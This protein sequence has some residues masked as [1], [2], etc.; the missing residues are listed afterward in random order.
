[1]NISGICRNC[2]AKKVNCKI[3]LG[4]DTG[5]KVA[6]SCQFKKTEMK[7]FLLILWW[8]GFLLQA[9]TKPE[10]T[11]GS[12][13]ST[14]NPPQ[15][16]WTFY[17]PPPPAPGTAGTI[18]VDAT[19]DGGGWWYPQYEGTG[20]SSTEYHQGKKLADYLKSL[21]YKVDELPRGTAISRELLASYKYVIRAGCFGTY[22]AGELEAYTSFLQQD[23]SSLFLIQD[24]LS[25][26]SNDPLSISLGV[27]FEGSVHGT[28]SY[29]AEHP[30]TNGV[31]SIPFIAGSVVSNP[32]PQKVSLLG[33]LAPAPGEEGFTKGVMGIVHHPR[34]KI[35]FIGDINGLETVPQPF[36]KNLIDWLFR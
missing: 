28:I 18:L 9:C 7:H 14:P 21:G 22:S 3:Q 27:M 30:V 13:S 23:S 31:Y 6:L 5:S 35:F 4:L 24:H 36:T 26:G 34:S 12:G 8:A 15:L 32:D 29:F 10:L 20:F 17:S 2:K 11:V 19:R 16:K 25:N 1:M 33:S